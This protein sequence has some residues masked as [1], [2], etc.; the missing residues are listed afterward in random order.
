MR[1]LVETQVLAGEPGAYRLVHDLPSIQVPPTVQAVLAA[2]ID[3]LPQDEKRLL[4]TAAVIGTEVPF[5]LLQAMAEIPDEALYPC[6]THLQTAAFLYETTLFPEPIYTF[7]HALTH[8]VAYNSLLQE[9][10]RVLHARI[11]DELEALSDDQATE[12]VERLA[13]HA[14]RGKVWDKALKYFCQAGD[15]AM[16]QSAYQEAV[17]CYEQALESIAQLPTTAQTQTRTIEILFD[18]RNA[19]VPQRGQHQRI[20]NHLHDAERLAEALNDDHQLGRIACYRCLHLRFMGDFDRA[21]VAGKRALTL[22]TTSGDFAVQ[23]VSQTYLGG[24]YQGI[25]DYRQSIIYLRQVIDALSGELVHEHFGQLLQPALSARSI[26]TFSHAEV[27]EFDEGVVIGTELLRLAQELAS[28]YGLMMAY[29]SLGEVYYRQGNLRQALPLLERAYQLCQ[30]A[31]VLVW[32]SQITSFLGASYVLDGRIA[33][34]YPHVEHMAES[35]AVGNLGSSRGLILTVLGEAL[36]CIGRVE[37]AEVVARRLFDLAQ[38]YEGCGHQAHAL[39]LLAES[40]FYCDP[41]GLF[42][43]KTTY[44][45]ALTLASELGMRP[46]QAHCRRGLGKLYSQ[47]GESERARIELSMAIE[48][49]RDMEMTFWLPETEAALSGVEGKV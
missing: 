6:L 14:I 1:T 7:K 46:L 32:M 23:V 30:D 17:T 42:Q 12:Q 22:A 10:R 28:P 47:I 11:V 34:A 18:L 5:T 41:P 37:Q 49:Y 24:V 40:A 4:Q 20:L 33:E 25:A 26:L 2:R 8:D 16:G 48:M 27:G 43:A 39:R 38:V 31:N 3:R 9:R 19:L 15:K 45:Q 29:K 21:I 35:L 13:N 44:Q 36:L